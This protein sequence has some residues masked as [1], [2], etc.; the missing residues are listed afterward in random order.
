MARLGSVKAAAAGARRLRAGG[1]GGGRALRRELGDE[2]SRAGASAVAD[3]GGRRLAA[4][5][6]EIF[7][8]GPRRARDP[9]R[10]R[11]LLRVA[12]T[13]VVAEPA[14]GPLLAAFTGACRARGA[15]RSSRRGRFGELLDQRR[16][17]VTLGPRPGWRGSAVVSVAFLRYRLDRGRGPGHPL[18]AR[19][20]SPRPA[21]GER[22]LVGPAASGRRRRALVRPPDRP[23]D[24]GA[25]ASDAAA[26]AAAGPARA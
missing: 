24:V 2:L 25:F 22:W 17:D 9:R 3:A 16:A 19:G 10:G 8:L 1:V 14:A 26:L 12:A 4:A 18:R 11:A 20:T 6:A 13:G 5:A 21:R 23:S 15:W 7:G